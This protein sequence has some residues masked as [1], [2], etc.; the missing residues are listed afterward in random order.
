MRRGKRCED[1][2]C[3]LGYTFGNA[4][5]LSYTPACRW[6]SFRT[7]ANGSPLEDIRNTRHVH[8]VMKAGAVYDAAAV[9][10][11]AKGRMGPLRPED[12][13]WWKGNS[14]FHP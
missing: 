2:P 4:A 7:S 9:L 12:S 11:S 6:H 14:R 8:I 13:A 1:G 5:P 10:A 3:G